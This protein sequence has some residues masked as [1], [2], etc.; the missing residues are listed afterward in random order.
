MQGQALKQRKT[1]T[2]LRASLKDP[3]V[4]TVL[5]IADTFPPL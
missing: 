3:V 1:S 2:F 5:D 4:T